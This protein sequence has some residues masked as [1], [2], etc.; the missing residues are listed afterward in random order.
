MCLFSHLNCK[1]CSSSGCG[2]ESSTCS[3]GC[4]FGLLCRGHF[5]GLRVVGR[6]TRSGQTHG[7]LPERRGAGGRAAAGGQ[8]REDA[9]TR[10]RQTRSGG[11]EKPRDPKTRHLRLCRR[12]C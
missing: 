2:V 5:G 1:W 6:P 12:C 3:S 11:H 7:Y 10:L 4:V 8:G 9:Q